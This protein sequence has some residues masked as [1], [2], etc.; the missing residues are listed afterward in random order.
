MSYRIYILGASGTG[1]S[2]LG[3]ALA[4]E[5]GL[6]AFDTDDFYWLPTD[7]PFAQARPIEDRIKLAQAMFLPR[8][9]WVI[10]GS[11]SSWGQPIATRLTHIVFLTLPVTDRLAR[12][13]QR[14]R[15]R[16]GDEIAP[17]GMRHEAHVGFLDWA[18]AYDDPEFT[19]RSRRGHEDWLQRQTCPVIRLD[20]SAS[21]QEL[22]RQTRAALDE[23]T[24]GV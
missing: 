11:F 10:A 23:G 6:Q 16:N 17:G 5:L 3:R 9:N 15:T 2:T 7:P 24:P 20:A 12:L 21:P 13:R 19:G 1:T 18:L 4:T 8:S 22:V 14:E